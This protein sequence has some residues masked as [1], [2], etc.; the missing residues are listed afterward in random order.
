M[1][2]DKVGNLLRQD[3]D[4]SKSV[5]EMKMPTLIVI[6][7]ADGVMP[8]HAVEMYELLGGGTVSILPDGSMTPHSGAQLAILPNTTHFSILDR[9][10]LLLP[11]VTQFLDAPVQEAK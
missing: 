6:G 2:A 9:A 1:L 10:N 5:A 8:A 4:W 11:I 3:Y 7:D